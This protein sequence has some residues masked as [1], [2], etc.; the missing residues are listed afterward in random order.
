MT[1]NIFPVSIEVLEKELGIKKKPQ[2]P[3]NNESI[4]CWSQFSNG[5]AQSTPTVWKY[6]DKSPQPT[7]IVEQSPCVT[8]KQ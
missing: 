6:L 8:V 7:T 5:C 1:F 4:F 2:Q 3:T